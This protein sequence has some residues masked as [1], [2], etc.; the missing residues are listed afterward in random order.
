ML[1]RMLRPK[2]CSQ[3][4]RLSKDSVWIWLEAPDPGHNRQA[5]CGSGVP[6]GSCHTFGWDHMLM[7]RTLIATAFTFLVLATAACGGADGAVK[8]TVTKAPTG[9]SMTSS[10][11]SS[12]A[13]P[14]DPKAQPAVDAYLAYM[15]ASNNALRKP[16]ALGQDFAPGADYTKYSFDPA[17]GSLSAVIQQ[18]SSQGLMM[19]GDPGQPRIQV[20]SIEIGAKPYPRVTL[21]DCPTPPVQWHPTDTKTGKDV[22]APLPSGVAAPPHKVTIQVIFYQGRWG[23]SRTTSDLRLTCSA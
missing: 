4:Q 3:G 1:H 23:V 5:M 10:P 18:F 6:R 16:R 20:Q 13:S 14:I 7:R 11:T 15:T 2:N 21:S 8:P 17:R 19:T 22:S 12:P 9:S